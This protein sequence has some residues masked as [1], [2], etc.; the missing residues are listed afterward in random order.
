M[1]SLNFRPHTFKLH[2]RRFIALALLLCALAAPPSRSRPQQGRG[3][4]KNS[5]SIASSPSTTSSNA[6]ANASAQ[7]LPPGRLIEKVVSLDDATQSYALYLPSAY[8][9]GKRW[10]ILYCLDPLARGEVPVARFREAAERYGWIVA[11]SH[12]SRNGTVKASFDAAAAMW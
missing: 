3:A 7:K 8:T 2:V 1:S 4:E 10:P 5:S 12:N 6:P 11:G 9:P